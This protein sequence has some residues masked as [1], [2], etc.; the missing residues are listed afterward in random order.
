MTC[1]DQESSFDTRYG[2]QNVHQCDYYG[3]GPQDCAEGEVGRNLIFY[4]FEVHRIIRDALIG[5]ILL[6]L[7]TM[8]PVLD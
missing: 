8:T 2:G 6:V 3:D 4:K 7:T 5:D 1:T